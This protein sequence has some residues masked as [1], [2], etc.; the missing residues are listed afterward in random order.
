MKKSVPRKT[1]STRPMP[2]TKLTGAGL[3]RKEVEGIKK[4]VGK[5]NAA[6]KEL[7]KD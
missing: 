6:L 5:R 1:S 7:M 4:N 3:I 2:P